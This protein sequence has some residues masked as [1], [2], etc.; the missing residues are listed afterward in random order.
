MTLA[1]REPD[2]VEPDAHGEIRAAEDLDVADAFDGGERGWMTCVRNSVTCC[3][4]MVGSS[5]ARYISAKSEPVPFTTTGSSA[6]VGQLAA[7][8]L[9]LGEHVDQR[10]VGVGVEHHVDATR[11]PSV[12]EEVT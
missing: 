5:A 8:L 10:L 11:W 12:L 9:H 4:F 7:H 6:S 2:R 3:G 1:G